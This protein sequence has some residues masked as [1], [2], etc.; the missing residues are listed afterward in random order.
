MRRKIKYYVTS[1][2]AEHMLTQWVTSIMVAVHFGLAVAVIG[3]G[4][5]RFSRPSYDPLLEMVNNQV[6][7]YGL[8]SLAAAALMMT[9]IRWPNII[10]LWLGMAWHTIWMAL[11]ALATIHYPNAAATPAVA[12]AGF[13]MID[14]ALLTARVLDKTER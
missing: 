8:W 9:P 13:A 14:A 3:G 1:K 5:S 11:F 10:G 2:A 6:W 4:E 7:I 12:Y